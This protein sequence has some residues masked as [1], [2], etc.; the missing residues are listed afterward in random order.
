MEAHLV[1]CS[2]CRG[3]C[4]SLKRTLAMCRQLPTPEV[5]ASIAASIRAAI[6]TLVRER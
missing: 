1:Q 4:D 6:Q 3:T 2:R 5:P